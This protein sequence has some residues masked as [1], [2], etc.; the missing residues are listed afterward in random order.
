MENPLHFCKESDM[1]TAMGACRRCRS[2][3]VSYGT[4]GPGR[5]G[6]NKRE[7]LME[8]NAARPHAPG[9]R[10]RTAHKHSVFSRFAPPSGFRQYRTIRRGPKGND[11]VLPSFQVTISYAIRPIKTS[12]IFHFFFVFLW[13]KSGKAAIMVWKGR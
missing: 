13:K 12:G 10:R 4:A 1:I 5:T 7:V 9:T 3:Q 8:K 2:A 6:K 11:A